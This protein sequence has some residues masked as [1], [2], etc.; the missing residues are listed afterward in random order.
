MHGGPPDAR[1]QYLNATPRY[2]HAR[3]PK[4]ANARWLRLFTPRVARRLRF[5]GAWRPLKNC[6]SHIDASHSRQPLVKGER[7]VRYEVNAV[8]PSCSGAPSSC[9]LQKP[10]RCFS[11]MRSGHEISTRGRIVDGSGAISKPSPPEDFA[12]EPLSSS[13][14]VTPKGAQPPALCHASATREGP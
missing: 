12:Q 5:V 2:F 1:Q 6:G 7:L 9:G 14:V 4:S 13:R 8:M 3:R 10:P 11:R